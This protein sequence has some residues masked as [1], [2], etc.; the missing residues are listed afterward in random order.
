MFVN[1]LRKK[2]HIT[3]F[4]ALPLYSQPHPSIL[5]IKVC[6]KDCVWQSLL[7]LSRWVAD[8]VDLSSL[9]LAKGWGM[10]EVHLGRK[11]QPELGNGN[12]QIQR[13]ITWYINPPVWA[14]NRNRVAGQ[15]YFSK[16]HTLHQLHLHSSGPQPRFLGPS[17]A[18]WRFIPP[19]IICV[20]SQ[21]RKQLQHYTAN[22]WNASAVEEI[23]IQGQNCDS[24]TD[25]RDLIGL[26]ILARVE[27]HPK[28][29]IKQLL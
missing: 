1:L 20:W 25:F 22:V 7:T 18:R 3:F 23:M 16:I 28:R 11:S 15:G 21:I 6:C 5:A 10:T 14:D 8:L 13:E 4:S 19:A 9:V 17:T 26:L 24:P 29:V 12:P 27:L 2:G